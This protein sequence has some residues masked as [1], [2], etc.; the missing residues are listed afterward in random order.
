MVL[1]MKI[2]FISPVGAFF[3]GAEVAIGNLMVYLG[4]QGYQIYNVI[5]DNGESADNDYINFMKENDIHLYQLKTDKWWWSEAYQIDECDRSGVFA[6]QHKN[7]FQVREII[8]NQNIDLVISNTVNV[9]QGALAAVMEGV[10][11]YYIIHEFPSGEFEYYKEKIALINQLSDK[12]FAVTGELYSE[13]SKYFPEKKLYSFL[14]Y[15]HLDITELKKASKHRIISIG[16]INRRKNQLELIQAYEKLSN[17]NLELIFIGGWDPEYKME[18]DDYISEKQLRHIKFWGHQKAPFV[19]LTDKDL[20]VFTSKMEA[21]PLVYVESILAGVPSIVSEALGHNTVSR[22]FGVNKNNMYP[23]GNVDV[24]VEK[25]RWFQDNFINEKQTA[26]AMQDK[27]RELYTLKNVSQVFIDQI[28][29]N[30]QK[31]PQKDF[32]ALNYFLGWNIEEELLKQIS[33]QKVTVYYSN[34]TPYYKMDVYQIKKQDKLKIVVEEA[35]FV[36]IDLTKNPGLYQNIKM[37]DSSTD[38]LLEPVHS[39]AFTIANK[40][41]FLNDDPQLV[42][43]TS[44]LH[45]HTL[46]FS[47]LR[48]TLTE[49]DSA[50]KKIIE[51]ATE[52]IN[53]LQAENSALQENN[54]KLQEQV[55]DLTHQYNSIV[56]S[57]RWTIPTKIINLFRRKK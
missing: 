29:K 57:R 17:P 5:P 2:L 30:H 13:L 54:T 39:N 24:L 15:S 35:N 46:Y 40:I 1:N 31:L 11:H 50:F 53:Q 23:L 12:I 38:N 18:L 6:Y 36:R 56:H 43:D 10:P 7:I 26:L 25:I 22:Y 8:K 34:E 27:A 19:S 14:P 49:A 37:L 55:S 32:R 20:I 41:I 47:Y 44:K 45:G 16:G 9:F 51:N 28:S 52:K 4:S 3:S 33:N 21:F 48:E 42:F